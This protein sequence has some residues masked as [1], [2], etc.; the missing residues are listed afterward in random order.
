MLQNIEPKQLS[1]RYQEKKPQAADRCL[2]FHEQAVLIRDIEGRI[3]LPCY[4]QIQKHSLSCTYLFAIDADAYFL[5][6]LQPQAYAVA[7]SGYRFV[8]LRRLRLWQP[9]EVVFAVMTAWHLYAW[10][11]DNRFCGRC[12]QSLVHST[13]ERRLN[14]SSCGNIVYPR[15]YPAVIVGVTNGKKLLMSKYSGRAYK[16]YALLAG[17]SEIGETAEQTVEREVMEEVGL[18]VKNIRYYKSQPW[19]IDSNLLF[20]YFAEVDGCDEI[21]IDT[22]ELELAQWYDK[23]EVE[24]RRDDVSLTNEMIN[25]FFDQQ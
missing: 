23:D 21:V 15:I 18:K 3:E 17:F 16:G 25:F 9:K 12:G 1:N 20:G 14:C 4:A 11:R 7:L 13:I 22:N 10:Y 8:P 5:L 19:G 6:Q 2:V 24:I